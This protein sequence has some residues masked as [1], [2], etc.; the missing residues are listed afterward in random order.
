MKGRWLA[1][2]MALAGC[3]VQPGTGDECSSF[4]GTDCQKIVQCCDFAQA[5]NPGGPAAQACVLKRPVAAQAQAS[6][7]PTD[8]GQC[9]D[10]VQDPAL[11]ECELTCTAAGGGISAT[12]GGS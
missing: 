8:D 7:D 6:S 10:M 3:D 9:A 1:I 5:N 11:A 2:L 4:D 12:G